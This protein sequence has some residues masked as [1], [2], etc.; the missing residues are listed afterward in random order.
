MAGAMGGTSLV[1]DNY[2][3][4]DQ[5]LERS[6]NQA[7][8][9]GKIPEINSEKVS[10]DRVAQAYFN[11][12]TNYGVDLSPIGTKTDLYEKIRD[13]KVNNGEQV[14]PKTNETLEVK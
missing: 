1:V 8:T 9:E 6:I 13:E 2:N 7:I 11:I 3:V 5:E 4:T 10:L 12:A 14:S